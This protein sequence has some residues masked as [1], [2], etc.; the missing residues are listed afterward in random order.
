MTWINY[1]EHITRFGS[2]SR[3]AF[4]VQIFGSESPNHVLLAD[5]D[6]VMNPIDHPHDYPVVGHGAQTLLII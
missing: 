4:R 6:F 3:V 2:I 1:A 5:L